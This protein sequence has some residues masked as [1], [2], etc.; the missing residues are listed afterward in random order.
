MSEEKLPYGEESLDSVDFEYQD[1]Y[2]LYSC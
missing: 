2:P 1:L